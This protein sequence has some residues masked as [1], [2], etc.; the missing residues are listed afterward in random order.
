MSTKRDLTGGTLDVNPQ[1]ISVAVIQTAAN[2]HVEI[3]VAMP[4]ARLPKTAGKTNIIEVL[5]VVYEFPGPVIFV[6]GQSNRTVHLY[7]ST[8]PVPVGEIHLDF[9]GMI[10]LFDLTVHGA[11][12]AAGSYGLR[13]DNIV[14]HDLTDG[15]GHGV[16]V[17]TDKMWFGCLSSGH[18]D[19]LPFYIRIYYRF[20]G[21]GLTEY[22]GIVQSQQ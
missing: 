12:T 9:T 22:I 14:Y 18:P 6:A 19:P 3:P 13:N 7:F 2:S 11:F 10:D 1:T 21:V 17:A 15:A 16:L 5:K 20:K 4:I 8:R